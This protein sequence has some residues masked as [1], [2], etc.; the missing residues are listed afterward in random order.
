MCVLFTPGNRQIVVGTKTGAITLYDVSSG[1]EIFSLPQA[2]SKSVWSMQI[3]P[4]GT[5]FLSLFKRTQ[6]LKQ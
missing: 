5:P 1:E 3:T 4:D 6:Q 2:H